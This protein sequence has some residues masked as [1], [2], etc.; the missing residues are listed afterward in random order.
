MVDFC[1][2]DEERIVMN[3]EEKPVYECNSIIVFNMMIIARDGFFIG[4]RWEGMGALISTKRASR[5]MRPDPIRSR[6]L[7]LNR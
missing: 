1:A 3:G 5:A 2:H 4:V 7:D 6:F